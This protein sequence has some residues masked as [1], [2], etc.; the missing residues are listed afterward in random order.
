VVALRPE[1][2]VQASLLLMNPLPV[3]KTESTSPKLFANIQAHSLQSDG[4]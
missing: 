2:V 3:A 1:A 4:R